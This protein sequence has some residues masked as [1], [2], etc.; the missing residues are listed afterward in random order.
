MCE[1]ARTIGQGIAVT[2]D[3]LLDSEIESIADNGVA[4]ADFVQMRKCFMEIC[5]VLQTQ[6]VACV[7]AQSET[8]G[9]R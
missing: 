8:F 7:E 5:Q 2:G 3:G 9:F 4:Y 6:V 1:M